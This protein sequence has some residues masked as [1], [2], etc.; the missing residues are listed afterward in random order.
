MGLPVIGETLPFL[1]D[2]FGFI[3]ERLRTHGPVFKTRI[4]A[5]NVV[6]IAGPEACERWLDEALITRAGSFPKPVLALFGGPSLPLLDGAEHRARKALVMAAF[7]PDALSAYLGA[8]D[9]TIDGYLRRIAERPDIA[10]VPELKRLAIET[11]CGT[12]LGLP[13]GPELARLVDDYGVVMRGFT[14]LPIPLPGTT[15]G[16]ALRARDRILSLYAD[17]I[18]RHQAEAST[19][20]LGRM[21]AARG[22]GG[23]A[24]TLP[25]AQLELHHVVLAGYIV[26]AELATIVLAVGDHAAVRSKLEAELEGIGAAPLDPAALGRLPYLQQVVMEVK[27]VC[28]ATPIVFGR[29]RESFDLHGLTIP[30]GWSVYLGVGGCNRSPAAF[31]DPDRFD[32]DR[33]GSARAEHQRH[34][35]AFVPQGAGPPEM[36]RCAG[37]EFATCFMAAF[38]VRLVTGYTWELPA[39]DLSLRR[40]VLPPEPRD[41]L[42]IRLRRR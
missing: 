5:Q 11:I 37:L 6:F 24:L 30:K 23:E 35:H 38:A 26:F 15:Y 42:R 17:Q 18:R 28:E 41:G 10:L 31:T 34:P 8:M 29:A 21:L 20:G 13:A 16:A 19:D 25:Q 12:M 22:P 39:Q 9:A 1:R 3:A 40:D 2:P 7:T 4:L 36:H 14:G 32:P 33:F 27:R